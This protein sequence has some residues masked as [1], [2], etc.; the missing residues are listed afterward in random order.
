MICSRLLWAGPTVEALEATVRDYASVKAAQ[1]QEADST[2]SDELT[3]KRKEASTARTL[4]R[5]RN[6]WARKRLSEDTETRYEG[7]KKAGILDFE[8]EQQVKEALMKMV[9]HAQVIS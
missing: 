5:L 3:E 7:M 2:M 6:R 1:A 4:D 9:D 8:G